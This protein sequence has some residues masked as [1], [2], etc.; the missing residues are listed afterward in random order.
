VQVVT[1]VLNTSIA[2]ESRRKDEG[3]VL[4]RALLTLPL[5]G[6]F[7]RVRQLLTTKIASLLPLN[8]K[9]LLMRSHGLT[10]YNDILITLIAS[11]H[12]IAV[13]LRSIIITVYHHHVLEWRVNVY[14]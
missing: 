11:F 8:N 3:G 10:Y 4:K 2:Q 13:I 7:F 12:T 9:G 5:K 14:L 1:A 6:K